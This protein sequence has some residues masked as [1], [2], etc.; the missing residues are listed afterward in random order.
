MIPCSAATADPV[1][2]I[3]RC[4]A[5]PDMLVKLYELPEL[6][7]IR[8]RMKKEQI[9]IRPGLAPEKHLVLA[10]IEEKF[11]SAW[12]SEADVAFANFPVT[13]LVAIDQVGGKIAGFACY[14]ATMRN[15]FGPLGV[16]PEYQG[17]GIGKALLLE[18]LVGLKHL[19]Y[20]YCIIGGAGPVDFY[21]KTAGAIPIEDSKPGVYKGLLRP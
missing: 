6:T 3:E 10:W 15:Y 14:E 12:A 9:V 18:A 21:A 19:G 20:A 4:P 1:Q 2:Q 8:Q 7:G 5:M 17:R 13:C 16:D 11:S